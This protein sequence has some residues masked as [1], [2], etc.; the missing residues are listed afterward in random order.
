VEQSIAMSAVTQITEHPRKPGRYVIDVD[1]REFAT[2]T[3]DALS[4]SKARIG[5]VVDDVLAA[6]LGEANELTAAY[7]RALNLL[8]SRARSSRELH[9]RLVQKGVTAE[10][11]D[12]V[13]AKL[14][15]AGLIDDAD[16]ARQLSRSKLLLGVSRRRVHQ[17]LFKRGVAREVADAAVGE[18]ADEEGLSDADSIERVAR[19]KWR[20]LID[21]DEP[22]RR[23]R[24]FAFLARRGF[25]SDDISR[26]VRRLA[27]ETAERDE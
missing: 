4:A 8:A 5:V 9:R 10:R 26:V 1:G 11:A 27:G 20:T 7:D 24:L 23:R 21:L 22:T 25:G 12:R 6:F 16:F 15:D 19:K 17:E 14:R 13:I 18:V 2:V 3:A